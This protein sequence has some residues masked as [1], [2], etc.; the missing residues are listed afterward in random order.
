MAKIDFTNIPLLNPAAYESIKQETKSTKDKGKTKNIRETKFSQVMEDY[1]QETGEIPERSVS[2]ETLQEL[3]DDVHSAGDALKKRPFP[4]EIKTYKQAVR[5]FLRYVVDNAY[6]VEE[7]TSGINP[8]RRKT[9]TLIQVTDQKLERL[10]AG[11][12]A[13]QISQLELLSRVDEIAGILVDLL[14]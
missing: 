14:Q 10:A 9:Y 6:A 13:G 3:L 2:E 1:L 7:Q 4:E 5:N 8:V 12:L 11:I